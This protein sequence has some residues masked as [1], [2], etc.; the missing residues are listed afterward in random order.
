VV[1]EQ[2]IDGMG[3][4]APIVLL[5]WRVGWRKPQS[6]SS[7]FFLKEW[8]PDPITQKL[9]LKPPPEPGRRAGGRRW[10]YRSWESKL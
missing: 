5:S 1:Q 7:G 9:A 3:I 2:P 4:S 6:I 10:S 8:V